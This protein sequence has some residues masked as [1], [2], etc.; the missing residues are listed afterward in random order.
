MSK[1]TFIKKS[2]VGIFLGANA[3]TILF[4]WL[5][6][7][8]TYFA[9]ETFPRLSLLGLTFP[10]FL[11]VNIGF[12]FFWLIFKARL[13][14][15]PLLGLGAIWSFAWDYCPFHT[16]T[17]EIPEDAICFVNYNVGGLK[18][19]E[20]WDAF[21][22]FLR[23]TN[24]DIMCMQEVNGYKM[25][26]PDMTAI[27]DSMGYQ[28]VI[29]KSKAFLTRFP[30]LG[31]TIHIDYPTRS[32][33]SVAFWIDYKGD[34]V[35]VVSNHL[36]SNHLTTADKTEYKDMIKAP[37]KDRVKQGGRLLIGKLAEAASYRGMQ[38]DTLTA[39]VEQH[40]DKSILL[41]GDFNDTPI[42]YA[43]QQ[44]SSKLKNTFR[45]KGTGTGFT[46]FQGG[47]YIRID[48]LFVSDDWECIRTYTDRSIDASDHYPLVS[49]LRKKSKDDIH[50]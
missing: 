32:N 39:L 11:A 40:K 20:D 4:M 33:C 49:F 29:G 31:D 21:I 19:D 42:S 45:E 18:E 14:W 7:L 9:P 28:H 50:N 8:S 30:I 6:V 44:L 22:N 1:T 26:L 3:G 16:Q 10:I 38:T 43:Y 37:E 12:C 35:L 23:Q 25:G 17:D 2:L 47:M 15:V 13:L 41:C 27:M 34:S 48:H 36:E 5:T 46:Y 24:P